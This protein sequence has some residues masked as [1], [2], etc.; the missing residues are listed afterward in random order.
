VLDPF[1]GVG[2]CPVVCKRLNRH[3]IGVEKNRHFVEMANA[4][5]AEVENDMVGSLFRYGT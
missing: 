3:F 2:T 5:L 4:R 1:A